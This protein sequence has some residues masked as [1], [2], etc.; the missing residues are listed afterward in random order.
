[1]QTATGRHLLVWQADEAG[2]S[3]GT[4]AHE[5]RFVKNPYSWILSQSPGSKAEVGVSGKDEKKNVHYVFIPQASSAAV[6]AWN[7]Q[8]LTW[9]NGGR[10]ATR[11]DNEDSLT[12]S[13]TKRLTYEL[14]DL[15]DITTTHWQGGPWPTH[16]LSSTSVDITLESPVINEAGQAE[17]ST[18]RQRFYTQSRDI[19]AS[20]LTDGRDGV[21]SKNW[22][23]GAYSAELD[24]DL[25]SGGD[26]FR[27]FEGQGTDSYGYTRGAASGRLDSHGSY[28]WQH[29]FFVHSGGMDDASTREAGRWLAGAWYTPESGGFDGRW[30]QLFA[31]RP[32]SESS[33]S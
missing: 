32:G 22:F 24:E 19:G 28:W 21:P 20:D 23:Y 17:V 25:N 1:M 33:L 4:H 26:D 11:I 6:S 31:D 9:A 2:S 12:W 15:A 8:P 7:A 18:G 14:Q 13:Q 29:D 5:L 16:W 10:M 30:V 3:T 27:G